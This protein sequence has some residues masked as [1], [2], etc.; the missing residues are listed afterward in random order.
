M[1]F[2]RLLIH[3]WHFLQPTRKLLSSSFHPEIDPY[4]STKRSRGASIGR[5]LIALYVTC[6][7][8][9]KKREAGTDRG[10]NPG[11]RLKDITVIRAAC[12][13]E[14][15]S[16]LRTSRNQRN[17]T[18]SVPTWSHRITHQARSP[19]VD[20]AALLGELHRQ[21]GLYLRSETWQK[22]CYD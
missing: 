18:A 7:T 5:S 17:E 1:Q 14:A 13:F 15:S 10:R 8:K 22:L 2:P 3:G 19:A 16:Y 12:R 9:V 4:F 20:V 21:L 6:G 11:A